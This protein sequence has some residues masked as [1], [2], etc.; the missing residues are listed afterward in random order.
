MSIM[1]QT[2]QTKQGIDRQVAHPTRITLPRLKQVVFGEFLNGRH[3]RQIARSQCVARAE[4]ER[5]V[6]DGAREMCLHSPA[7]N[8][9]ETRDLFGRPMSTKVIVLRKPAGSERR[10]VEAASGVGA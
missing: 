4:V 3:I 5:V 8:F 6:R 10:Q 9:R 2:E 7:P 1:S